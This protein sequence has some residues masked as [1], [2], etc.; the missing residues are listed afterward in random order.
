LDIAKKGSGMAGRTNERG[1][2]EAGWQTGTPAVEDLSILDNEN[3][4]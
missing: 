1:N 4:G 3:T 2:K